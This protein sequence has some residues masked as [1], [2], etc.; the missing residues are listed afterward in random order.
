MVVGCSV[1]NA[2]RICTCPRYVF[3]ANALFPRLTGGIQCRRCN[4]PIEKQAVSSSDGQLKGKY[5]RDCFNCHSCHVST[6]TCTFTVTDDHPL[7]KPFPD[8]TFYVYEG[9]PYCA[10]H[11]HEANGSL[12]AASSCGQPIEGPCAVSH[13]GAKYHAEHFLCEFPRC[14]I[15][16]DEYYEADGKMFCERHASIAEQAVLHE[17]DGLNDYEDGGILGSETPKRTTIAMKRRTMFID[18][19]GLGIR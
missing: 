11:Y 19:A 16:L 13:S 15:R 14:K 3:P 7:Q 5:H 4:L 8:K 17:P 18:I 1:I 6:F 12:C 10:Y 2:G 9:R